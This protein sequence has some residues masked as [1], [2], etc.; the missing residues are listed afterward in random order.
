[1]LG[2]AKNEDH[3]LAVSVDIS[4]LTWSIWPQYLNVTDRQMGGRH[5]TAGCSKK[6]NQNIAYTTPWLMA[7]QPWNAVEPARGQKSHPSPPIP[8]E[9]VS[10]PIHP[11]PLLLPSPPIREQLQ[12][13]P[14][15]S[16]LIFIPYPFHPRPRT[17]SRQQV[18]HKFWCHERN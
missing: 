5:A 4:E 10:I 13:H 16:P 8:A 11:H 9:F 1:M 7:V 2:A 18:E 15:P 17:Y 3:S 14:R 12:F 6:I